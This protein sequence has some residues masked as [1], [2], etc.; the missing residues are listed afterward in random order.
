MKFH[1]NNVISGMYSLGGQPDKAMI[2]Y[3]VRFDE[4]FDDICYRGVPDIRIIVVM[5]TPIAAMLRLPTAAS[6]GKANLHKGGVGVGI[7]LTTGIS[8]SGMQW[9]SPIGAHPDTGHALT[10][11]EIPRIL[12]MATQS[13]D[14]TQLGYLGVD[15][16]LDRDLGP[17]LLELNTRPGIAIQTALGRGLQKMLRRATAEYDPQRSIED[18]MLLGQKIFSETAP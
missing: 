11:I 8:I 14:V 2:E 3:R 16:V 1:I 7:D 17:L 18:R 9:N 5:G 10:Q 15:I 13:Y 4:R 6:D 12:S